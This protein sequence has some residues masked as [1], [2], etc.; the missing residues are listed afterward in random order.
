MSDHISTESW[1]IYMSRRPPFINL[2]VSL[3]TI[4]G[5][6]GTNSAQ[7]SGHS[8]LKRERWRA[9]HV[10]SLTKEGRSGLD[11]RIY[12][13]VSRL[14]QVNSSQVWVRFNDSFTTQI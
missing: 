10:S 8:V 6:V 5:W 7:F 9:D 1:K 4:S 13:G 11:L 12:L 14:A 3:P 2:T